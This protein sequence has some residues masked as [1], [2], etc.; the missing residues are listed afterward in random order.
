M[1]IKKTIIIA[2]KYLGLNLTMEAKH[3]HRN[4]MTLPKK[5][6]KTYINVKTFCVH[7]LEGFELLR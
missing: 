2:E 5:L 7:G 1:E 3:T 6:Q 4:Y